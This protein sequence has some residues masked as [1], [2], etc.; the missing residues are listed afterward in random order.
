MSW[1]QGTA[2]PMPED[3]AHERHR[4][5]GRGRPGYR[6]DGALLK[7]LAALEGGKMLTVR[8]DLD[9]QGH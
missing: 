8:I 9:P 3:D 4:Q 7:A 6:L 2:H 1:R 5:L